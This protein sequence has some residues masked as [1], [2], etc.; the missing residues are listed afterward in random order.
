MYHDD[1]VVDEWIR[2]FPLETIDPAEHRGRV[3]VG[4]VRLAIVEQLRQRLPLNKDLVRLPCDLFVLTFGSPPLPFL[5][6]IGGVPYRARGQPWPLKDGRPL[7]FVSQFCFC[8]SRDIVG[9]LPGDVLLLFCDPTADPFHEAKAFFSFEWQWISIAETELMIDVPRGLV[10]DMTCFGS[11]Y[12]GV[13]YLDASK[14]TE[15]AQHFYPSLRDSHPF[16]TSLVGISRYL[17]IK[18]GGLPYRESVYNVAPGRR[19]I[20][21]LSTIVPEVEMPYPYLNC[22]QPLSLSLAHERQSGLVVPEDNPMAQML[23]WY[24]GIT[25]S[26]VFDPSDSSV[27]VLPF[28]HE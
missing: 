16:S 8:D 6:K 3:V 28:F 10:V 9:E 23:Y 11:K 2:Q 1:L 25:F 17:G 22:P 12:R 15:S 13:D 27:D 4:P 26:V 21:L 20:A 5:T 18:I 7:K 24:D 19:Q 14:V